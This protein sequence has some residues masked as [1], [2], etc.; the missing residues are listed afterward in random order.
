MKKIITLIA[1]I[2]SFNAFSVGSDGTENYIQVC[3]KVGSDGT[4][5][6]VGSDGTENKVGSD[7]TENKMYCQIIPV[8]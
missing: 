8:K 2:L 1:L 4:E 7:G 3:T 5:N 6:K